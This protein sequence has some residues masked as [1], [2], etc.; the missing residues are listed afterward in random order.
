MSTCV[1]N[2]NDT[3]IQFFLKDTKIPK[4]VEKNEEKFVYLSIS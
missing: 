1:Q 3:M 4:D 2:W